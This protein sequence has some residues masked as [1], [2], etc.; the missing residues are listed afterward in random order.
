MPVKI[1]G[2]LLGLTK[3]SKFADVYRYDKRLKTFEESYEK[4]YEK[5]WREVEIPMDKDRMDFQ[6]LKKREQ[7]PIKYSLVY[8]ARGDGIVMD[9]ISVNFLSLFKHRMILGLYSE[10]SANEFVHERMYTML[11]ETLIADPEE[12]EALFYEI[13]SL[14][15]VSKKVA[16]AK[17]WIDGAEDLRE[18]FVAFLAVEAIHFST[19]FAI[20]FWLKR[21]HNGMMIGTTFSNDLIW[22]DEGIHV[23]VMLALIQ[24]F[25]LLPVKRT[26]EILVG[27]VEAELEFVKE[28]I[29]E[30]LNGLDA[31]SMSLF[32][33]SNMDMLLIELY[34]V[35]HY[36]VT[37]PL[38]F[39]E[40]T[41]LTND[42]NDFERKD[43][44]S[45]GNGDI[46]HSGSHKHDPAL[47]F[48]LYK[49]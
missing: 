35:R 38:V 30:P 23:R 1:I 24:C 3:D 27:A 40:A 14:P 18:I 12:R 20:L 33:K 16:W 13:E 6:S 26:I 28:A 11:L 45:R 8:F 39:M 9:N 29:P 17:K 49:K 47:D 31:E 42:V 22:N 41:R 36:N 21:M 48:D 37:N 7:R 43:K 5:R 19:S 46:E 25:E 34:G 10:I 15:S 32:V 4:L 44:Y 2:D